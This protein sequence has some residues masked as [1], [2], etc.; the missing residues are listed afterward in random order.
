MPVLLHGSNLHVAHDAAWLQPSGSTQQHGQRSWAVVWNANNLCRAADEWAAG[1]GGVIRL[2][3]SGGA[4]LHSR[5]VPGRDNGYGCRTPQ[6]KIRFFFSG[7]FGLS[8]AATRGAAHCRY[9]GGCGNCCACFASETLSST[10]DSMYSADSQCTASSPLLPLIADPTQPKLVICCRPAVHHA[11]HPQLWRAAVRKRHDNAPVPFGAAVL[12]AVPAPAG[13][14]PM[15]SSQNHLQKQK[16]S[17]VSTVRSEASALPFGSC[18]CSKASQWFFVAVQ[19]EH[20]H[21]VWHSVHA[22]LGQEAGRP[23]AHK[24]EAPGPPLQ[25]V[26]YRS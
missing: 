25:Q 6:R 22:Q 10:V 4:G 2:S 8:L 13:A 20:C 12:P 24:V 1:A 11:H 18:G 16:G 23:H 21:G 7:M 14:R 15:V 5:A 3:A 17:S 9:I 19:G 26:T